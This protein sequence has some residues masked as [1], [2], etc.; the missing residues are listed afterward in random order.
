MGCNF[1]PYQ[2]KKGKGGT[3]SRSRMAVAVGAA[4]AFP[5]ARGGA[6]EQGPPPN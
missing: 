5:L 1:T 2:P 3:M 4:L 6:G